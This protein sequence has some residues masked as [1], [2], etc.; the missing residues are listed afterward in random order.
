MTRKRLV[1]ADCIVC[2][3]HFA[4]WT[5]GNV[6]KTCSEECYEKIKGQ[7]GTGL[8]GYHY[9]T[10]PA[11]PRA[12]RKNPNVNAELNAVNKRARM[13]RMSYGSYVAAFRSYRETGVL[14][15]DCPEC[16]VSLR[17]RDHD[18]RTNVCPCCGAVM[19]KQIIADVNKY[20][21]R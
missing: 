2:G 6:R 9:K 12:R 1:E 17:V 7:R 13:L 14:V 16:R 5:S 21:K 15:L 19:P 8:G 3:K 10:D 4:A 18:I 20:E 11:T